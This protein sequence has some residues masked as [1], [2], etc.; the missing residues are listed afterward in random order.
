M[1]SASSLAQSKYRAHEATTTPRAWGWVR[2]LS[3]H[4]IVTLDFLSAATDSFMPEQGVV[5][6]TTR[7]LRMYGMPGDGRSRTR[8]GAPFDHCGRASL[9]V[10]LP[11]DE[12]ALLVKMIVNLRVKRTE[13]L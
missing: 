3:H 8:E 2:N 11:R 4:V 5:I 12:M 6:V 7:A 1:L 13:L 9:F 10:D